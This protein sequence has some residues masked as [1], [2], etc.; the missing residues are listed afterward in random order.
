MPGASFAHREEARSEF[1]VTPTLTSLPHT[2]ALT[3]RAL[4]AGR[5][6]AKGSLSE[7]ELPRQVLQSAS[8]RDHS[9]LA[10]SAFALL[11]G[12]ALTA[13]WMSRRARA[14]Y[15]QV[16]SLRAVLDSLPDGVVACDP[17]GRVTF[18]NPAGEALIGWRA[19]EALGQPSARVLADVD[20]RT[21]ERATAA[22]GPAAHGGGAPTEHEVLVTRG[23][24][25]VP[26]ECRAAPM[27]D[28]SGSVLL[29]RDVSAQR[30]ALE[31]LRDS[32]EH[33]RLLVDNVQDYSIIRL[34]P[35]GT[36]ASWNAG[37]ERLLGYRA[38]EI[39]GQHVSRFYDPE[40][41]RAGLPMRE[42]ARAEAAGRA[43]DE[44]WRI[45]RDGSRF[46]ANSLTTALRDPSGRLRGFG[47]VT[48][49]FTDR[50]QV[51][52]NLRSS[53]ERLNRAQQIAHL[54]SWDIDRVNG[55]VTW[56]SETYRILGYEPGEVR[57]SYQTFLDCVHSAD[58][59]RFDAAHAQS[60]RDDSVG[61]DF[62]HRILLKS[63]EVRDLHAKCEHVRDTG[64]RIVRSFG[65]LHDIT[66]RKKTEMRISWL[67]S[68]PQ[69]DGMPIAEIDLQGRL[70]YLNPAAEKLFPDLAQKRLEHPWFCGWDSVIASLRAAGGQHERIVDLG[71]AV[72]RQAISFVREVDA[73]ERIRVYGTD[74][75]A[76]KRA[77]GHL[78]RSRQGLR[79]LVDSSLEI[80]RAATLEAMLQVAASAAMR[81]TRARMAV[82]GHSSA[83]SLLQ[84]GGVAQTSRAAG[85]PAAEKTGAQ[86]AAPLHS[87]AME[88]DGLCA[89]LVSGAC[90]TLRLTYAELRAHPRGWQLWPEQPGPGG[91]VGARTVDAHGRTSGMILAF[92][93]EQGEFTEEDESLLGQLG[94]I[95]SLARQHAEARWKLEEADSRKDE[96]LAML[97]HELRNPLAPI[98]NSLYILDRVA[99]GGEKAARAHRIIDRQTAHMTRLIDDLLDVTRISSGKIH[100]ERQRLELGDL[101]R[102]TVEDH[103]SLFQQS[104]IGLE[105]DIEDSDLWVEGDETRLAQVVGNLLQNAAKFT[106]PGGTTTVRVERDTAVNQVVLRM[107]DTGAGLS[108]E[109]LPRLF[110]PFVQADRTLDRSRGGLGLGLHLVKR[111]VEM[112]GGSVEANSRGIGTGAEFTVRLPIQ[113]LTDPGS[114]AKGPQAKGPCPRR[115]V[116]VIEDNI[117]AAESL[118]EAL[119]LG[120]HDVSVAYNGLDGIQRAR[121]LKPDVVLCDIGLPGADGYSVARAFRSDASLRSTFLVALTGYAAPEDQQR[122][123]AA[124][125]QGHLAKPASIEQL[126]EV[127]LLAR[128][129]LDGRGEEERRTD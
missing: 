42:L 111:L 4:A 31:G 19:A 85:G 83:D 14:A 61:F 58:R 43:E 90:D 18:L 34:A 125:F 73:D 113:P 82:A 62:E 39:V 89:R 48:R 21:R 55:R 94:A 41:V 37:S 1:A 66:E 20:E 3:S 38:E 107:R 96:F 51:V 124:G 59:A 129:R 53:E 40:E 9:F 57:P 2:M 121:E 116:L 11:L 50:R 86:P 32:E 17:R 64:G 13:L 70:H 56:S 88:A 104:N 49:D 75:T 74:V 92:D 109:M 110:K 115:R 69:R 117:D 118:K 72:Y 81:L 33:L 126:E 44:S 80:M 60:M 87:L 93:R 45:R 77:E 108:A 63:G 97:S 28:G 22:L 7:A 46:W 122:A 120:D 71:E 119:E 79:H 25:D 105:V 67:A 98:R 127:L 78:L 29:L 16:R 102:R 84:V 10:I 8:S 112:H 6:G 103:R 26:I 12:S 101:T 91:L 99:H 15:R 54:G 23:G 123:A 24:R 30:R 76:L 128:N 35:D 100:I 36:V 68:F 114:A 65:M 52:D 95:V 106:G 5:A 47:S 27:A